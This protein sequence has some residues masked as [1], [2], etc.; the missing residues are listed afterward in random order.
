MN[1][2][3]PI[4]PAPPR[5]ADAHKGTFGTVV[6]VGGSPTMIGAPALTARSAFR[7]GAGLVKI[8][9]PA[10]VLPFAI[11]IE[12]SATGIL[13]GDG[14]DPA[15]VEAF[16]E[17][18]DQRVVFAIGPGLG[19]EPEAGAWVRALIQSGHRLVIDADGLN[20]LA[21]M[22]DPPQADQWV[23]TP[24]PGEFRRLAEAAGL[25]ADPVDPARRQEAAGQLAQHH[26]AVVV[27][28]GKNSVVH[29]GQRSFVNQTGNP[30]LATAGSGDVLTGL[31]GSFMAQGMEPFEAAVLAVHLHGLAAD[32]WAAEHGEA[33]MIAADLT[34]RIPDALQ[35]HRRADS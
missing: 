19:T 20:C 27:L 11:D 32:L 30:A 10:D 34:D 12:P 18:L 5:P 4:P 33:G 8:A 15:A 28:K 9:A 14:A 3:L 29:D 31:I 25:E 22:D 24:H 6:I 1:E 13:L 16:L 2:S 21:Q 35:K 23:L 17:G 7:A 26:R